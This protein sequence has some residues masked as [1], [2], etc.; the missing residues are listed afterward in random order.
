MGG[1]P[2]RRKSSILFDVER[3]KFVPDDSDNSGAKKTD[4]YREVSSGTETEMNVL[5]KGQLHRPHIADDWLEYIFYM[6]DTF[7]VSLEVSKLHTQHSRI[8]VSCFDPAIQIADSEEAGHSRYRN[9][10]L[11]TH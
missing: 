7:M 4:A 6:N 1:L 8:R 2:F 9:D 5:W 3:S 10:N 11:K